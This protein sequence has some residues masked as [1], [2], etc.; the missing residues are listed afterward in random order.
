MARGKRAARARGRRRRRHPREDDDLIDA[1]VD[2]AGCRPRSG[3]PDRRHPRQLRRLRARGQRRAIR[4]RG[5]RVR[6]GLL[7]QA[8]EIRALPAAAA[9]AHE[10]RVR[11]RGHLPGPGVHP[12]PVPPPRA[13]RAGLGSDHLERVGCCAQGDAGDGRLDAAHRVRA[14]GAGGVACATPV[15]GWQRVRS[16]APRRTRR[17]RALAADRPAQRRERARS[18]RL[19]GGHGRAPG[20]GG[21]GARAVRGRQAAARAARRGGRHPRLRRLRSSPDRHRDHDRRRT[22][23]GWRG[24]HRRGARAALEHDAARR[25]PRGARGVAGGRRQHLALPAHRP[26]LEPRR[27]RRGTRR[28]GAGPRRGAGARRLAALRARAA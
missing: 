3:L 2:P 16:A 5:R 22:P 7:R 8:G 14:R 12:A 26:R 15:A 18:A 27:C 17:H 23:P 6:H 10:P 21:G 25:A 19:R 20:A 28:E 11:P 1:G 9:A 24:T 13:H 4:D